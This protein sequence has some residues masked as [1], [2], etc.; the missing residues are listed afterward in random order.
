M[1]RYNCYSL[2]AGTN[3][4]L[5]TPPITFP[6]N[7]YRVKFWFYRDAYSSYLSTADLVNVY[8]NTANNLTGATS[9][10]TVNRSIA[11][12]PVVATEGWYEYSFNMPAGATGSGRYIIFEAVSAFGDNIFLDDFTIEQLPPTPAFAIAPTSKDFG[13]CNTGGSTAN[14]TFTISNASGGALTVPVGGVTLTGADASQF[15][16]TITTALPWSLTGTSTATVDVKF[17]PTSTGLKNATLQITD[18]AP[19]S[20]HTAA[21][22]GTGVASSSIPWTEEFSTWPPPG[23]TLTGGTQ[24]WAQY[25]TTAA[26]CDFWGWSAGQTA[27]MITPFINLGAA[28]FP[29][30]EFRWSHLYSSSYPLDELQV[31]VSSNGGA[32][33]T[34]VWDKAGA[35]LE[36][37]DGAGNTTPG[38]Y[39]SSGNI[40]LASF[41]GQ[42]IIVKFNGI[43]GFGPDVFV[44][45]VTVKE[46]APNDVGT[47][48]VDVLPNIAVGTTAPM[49]T[50]KNYGTATQTFPVTMTITGG[51]SSTQT[52][53]SLA[54]GATAPV[55]FANW[56]PVVGSYIVHVATQLAGDANPAND[57]LSKNVAVWPAIFSSGAT[58]PSTVYLGSG[59]G[60]TD[61]SA[62]TTTGYLFS[63][64]GLTISNT[65]SESYKYN[66]NTNTWSMI[67]TMPSGANGRRNAATAIVGTSLYA[68]G[69]TDISD[70]DHPDVYKY[71]IPTNAWTTVAP[72]AV[73]NSWGKAVARNNL[74]Y[75]VGGIE[76]GLSASTVHVYDVVANTWTTATSLPL[77]R[78][79]GAL[80]IVGNQ[81]IYVGGSDDVGAVNTV[82]VGTIDS[83]NPLLIT[84]AA[85]ADYP[86]IPNRI[87]F[88]NTSVQ[89]PYDIKALDNTKKT[90]TSKTIGKSGK[91]DDLDVT[92]P[93]GLM[94]RFDGA[95]WGSDGI[96]VANGSPSWTWAPANPCPCYVY[97]PSTNTWIQQA[98]LPVPVTAAS[99][100]TCQVP[101]GLEKLIVAGGMGTN[102]NEVQILTHSLASPLNLGLTAMLSG[103]CN[104][105][106]MN[107]TKSVT[108][109]LH[110]SGTPHGLIE[111][112]AVTLSTSGTANPIF[113]LA[114]N[115]TP[116]YI[117]IKSNNGLETWSA[118]PQT[119]TGSTL[120]YDFTTAATQAYGSNELLVGT[121]WCIISGD[122]DQNGTINAVDRSLCWNDRNLVGVYATDF[123]GNGTVNALDRSIAWNNRNLSVAKPALVLSPERGAKQD[124]KVTN[125]NTTKGK[126]F[127]LRLD[128]S[129][130]KKV[131]KTK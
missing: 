34:V 78:M 125:D 27:V 95:P 67:A 121:K 28:S 126:T 110:A 49:A 131:T 20:P 63:I 50:V 62:K 103:Y 16:L 128:G 112:Q 31:S 115:G 101:G 88:A 76:S 123:D 129:N 66:A 17:S 77:A 9:L 124:N 70:V 86:G 25:T 69:G 12:A 58:F 56:T 93:P 65:V 5:V 64:G 75:L 6:G 19:G 71:D 37:A 21:L 74:I 94:Y 97:I 81:L 89:H 108:V 99:L 55:T 43:S 14:Q 48:S 100:G 79:G 40:S 104:G 127:D 52:V 73:T 36:S 68:I 2:S 32:T 4:I 42:T 120:N 116:Y 22:T 8:Y 18:N 57:T 26:F 119:F 107:Y 51:Y 35:T 87:T 113:T 23:F 90:K 117:V 80:S 7:D 122:A 98:N 46:P 92:Y 13:N 106:T 91:G 130:A 11:L 59:V 15:T 54:P 105:T 39:V 60:Y 38:T 41:V 33:W 118:T 1:T 102:D 30:L 109:E 72:L 84:W 24:S 47:F 10:G 29:I 61:I 85:A 114:T 82:Y 3:G 83:G 96:I 111:S 45:E 44:D 53:T